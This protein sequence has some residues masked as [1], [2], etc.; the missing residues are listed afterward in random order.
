MTLQI[1]DSYLK[2][3]QTGFLDIGWSESQHAIFLFSEGQLVGA[4]FLEPTGAKKIS[5]ERLPSLWVGIRAALRSVYTSREVVRAVLAALEW[6][7]PNR[8]FAIQPAEIQTYLDLSHS[9]HHNGLYHLVWEDLEGFIFILN[10]VHLSG[11]TILSTKEG[12]V[13]G[14]PAFD[15][16]LAH[17]TPNLSF[18]FYEASLTSTTY[19]QISFRFAFTQLL[20]GTLTR[21]ERLVGSDMTQKLTAIT[22]QQL[23]ERN[24]Q[25][26]I[27]Q[28][29]ILDTQVTPGMGGA[30]QA[31]RFLFK[32][33]LDQMS[34][35]IGNSL[36]HSIAFEVFRSM[37]VEKQ[38]ILRDSPLMVMII[39][40]R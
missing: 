18:E 26:A 22:N 34:E 37:P 8:V 27:T 40:S 31:Y 5:I 15:R 11:E 23:N 2:N 9:H 21:Y 10:G 38:N 6:Y 16:L 33:I 39:A 30:F 7:P 36:A 1:A 25:L 35:M 13:V 17:T 3:R 19:Q 28:N 12:C 32:S 29:Q 4:S 24:C 14:K 20:Q